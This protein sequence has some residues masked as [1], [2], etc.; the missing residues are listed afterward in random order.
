MI[1]SVFVLMASLILLGCSTTGV[2]DYAKQGKWYELGESD[3]L[4]GNQERALAGLNLDEEARVD[5]QQ[6]Y[7]SGKAVYCVSDNAWSLGFTGE[8]YHGICEDLPNGLAFNKDY[9][10]GKESWERLWLSW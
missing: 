8:D 6:G 4:K 3:A 5:Y 10:L 9:Q 7:L 1:K 2:E